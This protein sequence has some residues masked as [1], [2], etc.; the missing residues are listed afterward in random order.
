MNESKDREGWTS[1]ENETNRSEGAKEERWRNTRPR[2][3]VAR[4]QSQE[5]E[6]KSVRGRRGR[7]ADRTRLKEERTARQRVD[8]RGGTTS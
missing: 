6:T 5:L 7:L 2:E 3:W 8:P 4:K 1:N